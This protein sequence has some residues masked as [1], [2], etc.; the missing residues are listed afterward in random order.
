LGWFYE[1]FQ[2]FIPE[3]KFRDCLHISEPG[4]AVRN[5]VTQNKISEVRFESYSR[6]LESIKEPEF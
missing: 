4:C 5:A 3:C 6:I 2:H 1:E